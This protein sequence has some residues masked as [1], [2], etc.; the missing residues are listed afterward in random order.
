MKT[1]SS[2]ARLGVQ[3]SGG[4][5]GILLVAAQSLPAYADSAAPGATT[6][7][8]QIDEI[9]VTAQKHSERLEDVPISIS[10][11]TGP[12]LEQKGI[13]DVAM[14][15]QA[16]PA[17][18]IDYSGNTVQP[19]IRGVGSQVAGPG[20]ISNVGVYVDG[21]YIPSPTASDI[22]LVNIQSVNVL[23]GPQGTL[24]GYN[25][26]GGAIQITTPNPEQKTSGFARVG[27]GSHNDVNAA[28]YGTTG[29][30]P[31]L[32]V[33]LTGAYDRGDSYVTNIVSGDNKAG[34]Y[35]SWS[36]RPKLLFT[37]T[38]NMSF[39]LAFSHSYIDDPWTQNTI[40]RDGQTIGTIIPGNTIATERGQVSN[41]APNFMH[42]TSQSTTLTSTF[43]LGFADLT[44]YTGY[45]TDKV[46][47]GL[48][49][50]DTPANIFAAQWKNPD[51]TFTQE[52]D[53]TSAKGEKL[54]WV[55]G[56]FYLNLKDTYDFSTNSASS[57]DGSGAPFNLLFT[58]TNN[59]KSFAGF[60]DATYQI[61]DNLYVTAGG[62]YSHDKVCLSFNLIPASFVGDGCST[63]SNFSPRGVVRYQLDSQSSVYASFSKGYKSGALPG[64]A[65]AFTP[66]NP[67]T[68][69]A[70]EVGYK[71]ASGSLQL[72]AAAFYYNYKDIQV[73]S[74]GASGTSITRNAAAAHNYGLDGDLTW[75]LTSDFSV[76]LSGA[77]THARYK[78]FTNAIG[79][80]QDLT[81]TSPS[82]GQFGIVNIN[83]NDFNVQRTPDFAGSV[84]ANYGF[85]LGGGRLVL[86][87]NLYYTSKFYFDAV[88]Q[89][90]QSS[91]SLL[92]LRGTWTDPSGHYSVSL[93]GTNV[94]SQKYFAQNFTDTFGSRAVYGPPALIGGTFAVH[95]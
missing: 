83:A 61:G 52:L 69:D 49:Y 12:A 35:Q 39:L 77:Y 20:L 81:P 89:L 93:F 30:S 59:S 54:Q 53:L 8:T 56:A 23:K 60:A 86:N 38:D 16:V 64:S 32:A 42:L 75:K 11:V 78:D 1:V 44:S 31:T 62:R 43:N 26:T 84:G 7:T 25:A 27:Y 88:Q 4:I 92:N 14:L 22:N 67:E 79:F 6:T 10:N 71:L 36:V 41:N 28:I 72:S 19:T 17:L 37:P 29:L 66:V 95:F 68:I 58:S 13:A 5:A 2:C 50:D 3:L 80:Q 51:S 48:E 24:F 63:F 21:Y 90:P 74:Y 18:R 46:D 82:Y 94:T 57:P 15:P 45:R 76:N 33:S 9:L 73:T 34:K 87:A 40:A 85:D 91:Y 70:F 65:F 55:V 47:Q